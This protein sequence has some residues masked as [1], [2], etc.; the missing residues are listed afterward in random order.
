VRRRF[1]GSSQ[2]T[3]NFLTEHQSY[4]VSR[5]LP[6]SVP[7]QKA[8]LTVPKSDFRFTPES[9]L[10]MDKRPCRLRARTGLLHC[11][12]RRG[13]L[14]PIARVASEERQG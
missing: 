10:E 4:T 7:G 11:N 5:S 12:E 3:K 13:W 6:M 14:G 8:A 2:A 1:L 9:G